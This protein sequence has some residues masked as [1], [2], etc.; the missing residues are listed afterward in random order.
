MIGVFKINK[1]FKIYIGIFFIVILTTIIGN[2]IISLN[3]QYPPPTHEKSPL[4]QPMKFNHF[5]IK[6][7]S[8]RVI[9]NTDLLQLGS[10]FEQF[11]LGHEDFKCVLTELHIKNIS[12]K[13]LNIEVFPFTL[14]SIGFSNGINLELFNALN[15]GDAVMN[16]ELKPNEEITLQL[17][18]TMIEEQFTK[19]DWNNVNERTF[20]LVLSLYPVKKTI[21]LN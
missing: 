14:E 7:T 16:P 17:P 18:F 2:R 5:E 21:V 11:T 4:K 15:G 10:E 13:N 3:Q 12:S 9:N 6:A 19:K 1:K 20:E 8:F